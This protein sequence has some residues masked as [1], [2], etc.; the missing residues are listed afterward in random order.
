MLFVLLLVLKE[1]IL[2]VNKNYFFAQQGRNSRHN[3]ALNG[4]SQTV[5]AK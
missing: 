1:S 2:I 5:L 4:L 3:L